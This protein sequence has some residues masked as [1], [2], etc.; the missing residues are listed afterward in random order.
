[1]NPK[2]FGE[3]N[4]KGNFSFLLFRDESKQDKTKIKQKLTEETL[5]NKRILHK[6]TSN[7]IQSFHKCN[8]EYSYHKGMNPRRAITKNQIPSQK[9]PCDNDDGDLII[10]VGDIFVSNTTEYQVIDPLGQGTFGQVVKCADL[11]TQKEIALKIIKN[12]PAYTN[13]AQV[14]IGI[15]QALKQSNCSEHH[16]VDFLEYFQHQNHLCLVFELLSFNLYE[17]IKFRNYRGLSTNEIRIITRQILDSLSLLYD[18]GIIHCDLKPENILRESMNNST[19][20]LIDFGSACFLNNTIYVYIQSRHY[21]SP[22]VLIG[23]RYTQAIDMW[24][25]GCVVAELFLGIPLFPGTTVYKQILRI[26]KMLGLP[27]KNML[28]QGIFSRDFFNY[29]GKDFNLK[30]EEQYAAEMNIKVTETKKYFPGDTLPELIMDYPMDLSRPEE[31]LLDERQSRI[32]LIHFLFGLLQYDPEKRWTPKEAMQHPFIT[33][34]KFTGD[35]TPKRNRQRLYFGKLIELSNN[36]SNSPLFQRTRSSSPFVQMKY[37]NKF[38]EIKSNSLDQIQFGNSLNQRKGNENENQN[39]NENQNENE[40]QNQNQNQNLNQN[41]NF[42]QNQNQNQNEKFIQNQNQNQNFIQ[43]QNQNQNQNENENQ[44]QNQNENQNQ[45]Q[46]QNFIQNE[47]FIQNDGIENQIKIKIHKFIQNENQKNQETF[48]L[49]SLEKNLTSDG[50]VPPDHE[51]KT[52]DPIYSSVLDSLNRSNSSIVMK[53]NQPRTRSIGNQTEFP[54]QSRSK[55]R[56]LSHETVDKRQI[57]NRTRKLTFTEKL[58]MR[59]TKKSRTK[60]SRKRNLENSKKKK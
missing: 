56:S 39:Q 33:N 27:P 7:I 36:P 20:K 13:Q 55:P 14:E 1:M 45:N 30:P 2:G 60:S 6:L 54:I 44:N 29:D 35:F 32:T 51:E 5:K 21:R 4:L 23:M 41:Q 52:P 47:K 28:K 34:Q 15:L 49:L 48:S 17:W 3:I 12:K 9:N 25:L 42:N 8:N 31:E 58:K 46:N 11:R 43:N 40:N 19:V 37:Q 38:N 59:F 10:F 57:K 26:T 16:I 50:S 18:F 24:S 22:E 53:R